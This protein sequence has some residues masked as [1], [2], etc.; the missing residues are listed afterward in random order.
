M[1]HDIVITP[2]RFAANLYGGDPAGITFRGCAT[3]GC[4]LAFGRDFPP[5][6]LIESN[7]EGFVSYEFGSLLQVL[8]LPLRSKCAPTKREWPR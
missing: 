3:L 4:F 1:E 5:K 8:C 7:E 6:F 2:L